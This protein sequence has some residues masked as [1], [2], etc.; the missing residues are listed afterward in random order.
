MAP[1]H[2]R[3]AP[4]PTGT[5]HRGHIFAAWLANDMARRSGGKFT[6]RIDNI[7]HTRCRDHFTQEIFDDLTWLGLQWDGVITFQS[8]RL[9]AYEAAFKKL[10]GLDLVYPCFLSRKELAEILSA[11]HGVPNTAII[12]NT[13]TLISRKERQRRTNAGM[14]AAWRLRM[15]NAKDLANANQLTWIDCLSGKH[16]ITPEIFGDVVIARGDIG[17]SYHL[18]VVVDDALDN[19]SLVTRGLDL[20]PSTHLHRLLQALLALPTPKYLHHEL[21]CNKAGKRLAKRDAAQSVAA[22]RLQGLSPEDVFHTLP[23]LPVIPHS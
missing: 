9:E 12:R 3:F 13:D 17:V 18:A 1:L 6:L 8:Q 20:A 22:M 14:A 21:I 16:H 7:D 11:P 19:I 2:T 10:Q 15:S 23:N 5:L 4:S